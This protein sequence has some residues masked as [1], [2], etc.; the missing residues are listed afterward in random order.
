MKKPIGNAIRTS[1]AAG[2]FALLLGGCGQSSDSLVKSAR[3]YIAK[4]DSNAALIQLR[5]ALQKAPNNAEARYLLGT[6]LNERRDPASA[7]KEL[8]KALE[9]GFPEDKAVPALARAMAADGDGKEL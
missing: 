4:G 2:L 9:L 8:R 6:L 7:V 5:N 3:D 1:V